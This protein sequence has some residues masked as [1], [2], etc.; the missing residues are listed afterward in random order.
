MHAASHSRQQSCL[1][2]RA[3]LGYAIFN[4]G[5]RMEFTKFTRFETGYVILLDNTFFKFFYFII[6]LVIILH[7]T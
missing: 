3:R 2:T 7:D 1:G 4:C 5:K 6:I